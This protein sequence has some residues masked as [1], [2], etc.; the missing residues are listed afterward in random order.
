[1]NRFNFYFTEH[2]LARALP[3][4]NHIKQWHNTLVMILPEYNIHTNLRVGMFLAQC[5]HESNNFRS[6]Q[7]NLN[8]SAAALKRVFSRYF[9]TEQ[10]ANQYA[11]KPEQIANRVYANRMGNGNEA[12]GDGWRYRGRGLI[13]LTGKYN[14]S[15][16][17]ESIDTPLADIP[18]YLGTFEGAVQS[19]CWFWEVN[20]INRWCDLRDVGR[21]T[22]IIN[23]GTNGLTD[24]IN[25]YNRIMSTL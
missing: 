18:S 7:E 6:L 5:S 17:A 25:R 4:N 20:D 23:G 16:F 12:S 1:M 21:V 24:R 11:R 3:G 10:L 22:R 13:Q 19:A 15:N 8:Y 2:K 14:Y 9:P